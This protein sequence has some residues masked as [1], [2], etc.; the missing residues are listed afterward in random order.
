[1]R[2]DYQCEKCGTR[3]ELEF[4]IGK[5]PRATV[6]P[7]CKGKAKR[8]YEGTSIAVRIGGRFNPTSTFGESIKKKNT[9]A[10]ERMKGRK[11]PLR[12]A[13]KE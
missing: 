5:A 2:Y 12:P 11:P 6:C 1:M 13:W 4:A 7:S 3:T 8:V 10:A 9:Q